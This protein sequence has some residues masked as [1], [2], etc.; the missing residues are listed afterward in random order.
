MKIAHWHG[1]V[2]DCPDPSPQARFYESLLGGGE[3]RFRVF[4]ESAGHPFCLIKV[5]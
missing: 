2:I 4:A 1:L 3:E 5:D